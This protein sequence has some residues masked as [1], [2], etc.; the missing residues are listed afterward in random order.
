MSGAA[1]YLGMGC[2]LFVLLSICIT[3]LSCYVIVPTPPREAAQAFLADVREDDWTGALQRMSA[4]Y[5][6]GH[7]ARRLEWAVGRMPNLARH[8]SVTFWNASFEGNTATLDGTLS[9]PEGEIAVA[10]EMIQSDGYWYVDRVV[11]QGTPLE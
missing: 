6:R 5:Q 7:D 2:G 9:S 1:R 4:A 8:T 3:F 11:L 10:F